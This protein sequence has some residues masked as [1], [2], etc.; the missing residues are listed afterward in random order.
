ML[1]LGHAGSL[2]F[3]GIT[4]GFAGETGTRRELGDAFSRMGG[5]LGHYSA[6]H[7]LQLG[8]LENG[9]EIETV[10]ESGVFTLS[11]LSSSVAGLKALRVR[12]A[13]GSDEW[14]WVESL[15]SG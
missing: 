4:L 15:L 8:W 12:R 1:G 14:L 13:A 10:D 6:R 7:K 5:G 9:T 11:P 2:D 3:G